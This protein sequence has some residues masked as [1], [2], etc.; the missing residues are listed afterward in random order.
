MHSYCDCTEEWLRLLSNKLCLQCA[1]YKSQSIHFR[2]IWE[3]CNY[4]ILLMFCLVK[5]FSEHL[6]VDP[7]LR[8][9]MELY[10]SKCKLIYHKAFCLRSISCKCDSQWTQNNTL[11]NRKNAYLNARKWDDR[12]R[13][14]LQVLLQ[15]EVPDYWKQNAKFKPQ[16]RKIVIWKGSLWVMGHSWH[17][18]YTLLIMLTF[19]VCFTFEKMSHFT[20]FLLCSLMLALIFGINIQYVRLQSQSAPLAI[21]QDRE[22]VMRTGASL[23]F[24]LLCIL[25]ESQHAFGLIWASGATFDVML[26]FL[27]KW[28]QA[29]LKHSFHCAFWWFWTVQVENQS[30][31]T[32]IDLVL[33]I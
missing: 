15:G 2:L 14:F 9:Y 17:M 29:T 1:S 4:N 12:S 5:H 19:D 22:D 33:Q 28:E 30:I 3:L 16:Q 26:I 10:C 18:T 32:R 24:M 11:M 6:N 8:G 7:L 20:Y 13:I 21:H 23:S 27:H 25:S 31:K